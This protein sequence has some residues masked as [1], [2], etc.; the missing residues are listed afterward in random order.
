MYLKTVLQNIYKFYAVSGLMSRKFRK[1]LI[2]SDDLLNNSLS[3]IGTVA[4]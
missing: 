3:I 2:V 1:I 4:V